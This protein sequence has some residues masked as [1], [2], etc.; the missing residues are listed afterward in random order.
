MYAVDTSV[1]S[2]DGSSV[3]R[4]LLGWVLSF[5]I[6]SA[7]RRHLISTLISYVAMQ[8]ANCAKLAV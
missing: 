3:N 4:L 2:S 6:I 5:S 7:L 1:S 8:P